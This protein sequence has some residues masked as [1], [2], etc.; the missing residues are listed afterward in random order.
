MINTRTGT[1]LVNCGL[2]LL[3]GLVFHVLCLLRC[4]PSSFPSLVLHVLGRRLCLLA[5]ILG[6]GLCIFGGGFGILPLRTRFTRCFGGSL[7]QGINVPL[8][9]LKALI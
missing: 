4:L 8:A 6:G 1:H 7:L 3:L 5:R 2:S 9:L